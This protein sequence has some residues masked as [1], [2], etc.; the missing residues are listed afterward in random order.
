MH[1]F[2]AERYVDDDLASVR[3]AIAAELSDKRAT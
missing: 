1:T 2:A 3:N